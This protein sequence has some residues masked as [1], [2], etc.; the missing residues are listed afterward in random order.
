[1]AQRFWSLHHLQDGRRAS[2]TRGLG[3]LLLALRQ[4]TGHRRAAPCRA[5]WLPLPGALQRRYVPAEVSAECARLPRPAANPRPRT[6][7]QGSGSSSGRA[8]S[9]SRRRLDLRDDSPDPTR[10]VGVPP[11]LGV[12]PSPLPHRGPGAGAHRH[13]P[14]AERQVQDPVRDLLLQEEV[15][16]VHLRR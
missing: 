2:S 15:P 6:A 14:A 4:G 10:G 12:R 16:G 5:P 9:P 1:M 11:D 7:T 8:H 3:Q 13:H